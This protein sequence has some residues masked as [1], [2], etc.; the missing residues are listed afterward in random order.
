MSTI[1]SLRLGETCGRICQ[2]S[3]PIST[4]WRSAG[5]TTR[6]PVVGDTRR[7]P[8]RPLCV[9]GLIGS[10]RARVRGLV[11]ETR[12]AFGAVVPGMTILVH[13]RR[14]VY[15]PRVLTYDLRLPAV[16]MIS[17]VHEAGVMRRKY[18]HGPRRADG[19]AVSPMFLDECLQLRV[20]A[21]PEPSV[22]WCLFGLVKMRV[23]LRPFAVSN[24]LSN[25]QKARAIQE[26]E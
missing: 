5:C 14:R 21:F 10:G 18:L 2:R 17:T 19:C 16:G 15:V 8:R 12:F 6:A 3:V 13:E 23:R 26:N 20:D 7:R 24:S 9:A 11:V 1:C 22:L 25:G 4:V